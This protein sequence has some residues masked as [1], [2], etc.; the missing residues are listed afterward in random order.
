[1][2]CSRGETV[3]EVR[4]REART[5]LMT[6][7]GPKNGRLPT[8]Q[9]RAG[10]PAMEDLR[11]WRTGS[12]DPAG[13]KADGKIKDLVDVCIQQNG[14]PYAGPKTEKEKLCPAEET[15]AASGDYR[16][17]GRED[18]GRKNSDL[19]DCDGTVIS[20]DW[21]KVHRGL[22]GDVED[23]WREGLAA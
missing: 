3:K 13:E 4:E 1:M 7:G 22:P 19:L 23:R 2:W 18:A 20:C 15:G 14:V 11:S 6:G 21:G 10:R 12:I 9:N 17:G 16:G 5:N 8:R